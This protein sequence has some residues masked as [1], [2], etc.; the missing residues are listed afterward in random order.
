MR[1]GFSVVEIVIALI[2]MTLGFFTFFSVFSSSAR[3]SAQSRMRT[4]AAR[5]AINYLE[6]FEAHPYGEPAPKNWSEE[7]DTPAVLFIKGRQQQMILHKKIEF[8]N[9]SFIGNAAD[10][11]DIVTLTLTWRENVGNDQTQGAPTNHAEDNKELVV[12]VPVW[13]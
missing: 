1:R 7:T 2:L 11:N 12:Q 3:Q 5:V 9:G 13:R 6:E 8:Q 4:L 10:N